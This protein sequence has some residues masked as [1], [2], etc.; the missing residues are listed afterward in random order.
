MRQIQRTITLTF[1]II[2]TL[3]TI[4][5]GL[6]NIITKG[7]GDALSISSIFFALF[8]IGL[9]VAY[10]RGW[11]YAR[12]AVVIS[13]TLGMLAIGE[14]YVTQQFAA[15]IFIVPVVALMLSGPWSVLVSMV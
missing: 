12:Y 2:L 3:G 13:V 8:Y 15:G 7:I 1:L 11:D 9:V 10:W 5:F 6:T 4:A 14:P